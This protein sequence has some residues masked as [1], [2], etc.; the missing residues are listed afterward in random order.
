M[1]L[2][3]YIFFLALRSNPTDLS[4]VNTSVIRK[5]L[6]HACTLHVTLKISQLF[7]SIFFLNISKG[8]S[9]T[10]RKRS[11]QWNL[12][13]SDC[14]TRK[15]LHKRTVASLHPWIEAFNRTATEI[16]I[17]QRYLY[18]LQISRSSNV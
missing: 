18:T 7:Q 14:S 16:I 11:T 8:S 5:I 17:S 10:I 3:K 13:S 4:R 12:N 9:E 15:A 2:K 6:Y 1:K